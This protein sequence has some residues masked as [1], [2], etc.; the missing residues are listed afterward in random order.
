MYHEERE[1]STISTKIYLLMR[2]QLVKPNLMASAE[3]PREFSQEY[4]FLDPIKEGIGGGGG[5]G[6]IKKFKKEDKY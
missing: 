2:H 5:G 6:T 3:T 4:S 1:I